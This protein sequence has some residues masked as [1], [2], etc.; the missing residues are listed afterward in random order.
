MRSFVSVPCDAAHVW[1]RR[2]TRRVQRC[3][4]A[5]DEIGVSR[6]RD[7]TAVE[8]IR[9]DRLARVEIRTTSEGPWVDDVFWLLTD[10][11]GVGVAIPSEQMPSELFARLASL[12]GWRS[13]AVIAAMSSTSDAIF[14]CWDPG[15]DEA[16]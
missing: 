3:T 1:R 2:R 8:T 11:E 6:L 10:S 5:S 13:E 7:G 16:G 4:I 14:S 12:P 9:W 15:G